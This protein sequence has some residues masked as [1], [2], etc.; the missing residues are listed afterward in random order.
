MAHAVALGPEAVGPLLTGALVEDFDEVAGPVPQQAL[1]GDGADLV[2]RA[3]FLVRRIGGAG[4]GLMLSRR[5]RR[6]G[7]G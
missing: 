3:V 6:S 1:V 4:V 7:G 2:E 5:E